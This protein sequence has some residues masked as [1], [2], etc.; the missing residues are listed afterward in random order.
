M[1]PTFFA[2]TNGKFVDVTKTVFPE[3]ATDYGRRLFLLTSTM[4]GFGL[5]GRKL[6][7]LNLQ[8]LRTFL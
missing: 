4:M 6:G 7:I 5:F 3:K 2:N 1:K 8:L